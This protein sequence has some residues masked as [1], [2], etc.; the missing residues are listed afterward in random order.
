[1]LDIYSY[2]SMAIDNN[3]ISHAYIIKGAADQALAAARHMAM[4]VNCTGDGV[5]PCG[6]CD[7]C[8][9]ITGLNHP[10][11]TLVQAAAETIGIDAVRQLQRD[12]YIRPYE[13]KKKVCI[14]HEG[15]KM[16]MQAQN[17]LLKV[18]E[19]PPS[20]G[21]VI[22]TTKN[23]QNLLPTVV[24]RCQ[25]L[26]VDMPDALQGRQ[27]YRDIVAAIMQKGF[28]DAAACIEQAFKGQN[29]SVTE[30]LDYLLI[31]LRDILVTKVVNDTNLVYIKNNNDFIREMASRL[32]YRKISR[33]IDAVSRAAEDIRHN[34]NFQLSMEA[35]LLEI[36][37][38]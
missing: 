16:T 33:L 30:F 31:T 8:R 22:I 36:Q 6:R 28:I 26:T 35:L 15:E 3:R 4:A 14:L 12:I 9:K 7:A 18:L 1:M 27:D 20:G 23:G 24:S 37:E 38:E 21:M 2:V 34:V 29:K 17:C 5:K 19:E 11:V 13:G 10:D 32:S 25:M